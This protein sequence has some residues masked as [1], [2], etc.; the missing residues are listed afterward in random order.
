MHH[1]PG[2]RQR[3]ALVGSTGGEQELTHGGGEAKAHGG[4]VATD[5]LHRVV[6]RHAGGHRTAGAIDVEPNVGVGVLTFEIQQL[7]TGLVGD[8][9]I[10]IGSKHDHS[11]LQQTVEHVASRVETTIE[12]YR[13]V[14]AVRHAGILPLG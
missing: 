10:H 4:D 2:V 14:A 5:E 3:V 12:G 1:D 7:G 9:I 11:V 6:D 13:R 8:V